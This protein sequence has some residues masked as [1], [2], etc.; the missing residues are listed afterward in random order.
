MSYA[1]IPSLYQSQEILM[2]K[3]CFAL[4]KLHGTSTRVHW[5]DP[6]LTF[7]SGGCKSAHFAS[8]FD[9]DALS[10]AFRELGHPQVMVY[11][12]GYGG[13]MQKMKATYG[14]SLRFAAFEVKIGEHWLAVPQAEDV[15]KKLG[16]EFVPY[17]KI[18][19]TLTAIDAE[20]DKPSVQSALNGMGDNNA[21]E[22]VVLHPLIE[23]VK[24]NGERIIAKHKNEE[25]AE[26]VN[27]PSADVDPEQFKILTEAAEVADEWVVPRRFE[28]VLQGFPDD[29]GMESTGDVIKAMVAD[30]YKES[31]G[32]IVESRTVAKAIGRKTVELLKAHCQ[33][34]LR[35]A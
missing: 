21:R 26:R 23:L 8:L 35:C 34:R 16:L 27:T 13:A 24:N 33:E 1:S 5:N 17:E 25:F 14:E 31:K 15:C 6:T 28:H 22:G 2:F 29:A 20:R 4:E 32:E 3:E 12:E 7:S 10:A 19:T 18:P 9:A 30:V 11:G